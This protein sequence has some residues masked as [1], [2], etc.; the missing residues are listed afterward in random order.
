MLSGF[1]H[2]RFLQVFLT[3]YLADL[4]PM[5]KDVGMEITHFLSRQVKLFQEER[6]FQALTD[7]TTFLLLYCY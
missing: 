5:Y 6:D 3:S 7:K 2:T 4:I 1:H